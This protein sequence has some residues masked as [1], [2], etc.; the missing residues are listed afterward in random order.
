MRSDTLRGRGGQVD[1]LQ[2]GT[3]VTHPVPPRTV[4]VHRGAPST[5]SARLYMSTRGNCDPLKQSN[6]I[7]LNQKYM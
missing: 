5:E 6:R 1:V 7:Q 3:D 2:H 4:P